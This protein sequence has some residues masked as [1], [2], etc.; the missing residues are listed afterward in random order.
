[1]A[2]RRYTYFIWI[3]VLFSCNAHK[4]EGRNSDPINKRTTAEVYSGYDAVR[5]MIFPPLLVLLTNN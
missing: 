5:K 4:Q 3:L 2:L 1:M